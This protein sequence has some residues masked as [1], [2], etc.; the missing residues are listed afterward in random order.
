[1]RENGPIDLTDIACCSIN[2]IKSALGETVLRHFPR[3]R[4]ARNNLFKSEACVQLGPKVEI[5]WKIG[6]KI[7]KSN[8]LFFETNNFWIGQRGKVND[9][10]T[11]SLSV[12]KKFREN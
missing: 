6:R 12:I 11:T 7:R 8:E 4:Y 10:F 9:R 5:G 2:L 1:M 3:E